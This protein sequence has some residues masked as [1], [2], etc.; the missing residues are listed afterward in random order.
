MF[1]FGFLGFRSEHVGIDTSS[2]YAAFYRIKNISDLDALRYEPGFLLVNKVFSYYGLGPRSVMVLFSLII[3]VSVFYFIRAFSPS[4]GISV[5]LYI[6]FYYYFF[7][8]NGVRQAVSISL[9]CLGYTFSYQKRL[10][11]SIL[12]YALA[13]LFHYTSALFFVSLLLNR[14]LLGAVVPY[15]WLASL[16]FLVFDE[17]FSNIFLSLNFLVPDVYSIY[18]RGM[19]FIGGI[20][21][22]DLLYQGFF[23]LIYFSYRRSSIKVNQV[24]MLYALL[25]IVLSNILTYSGFITRISYYWEIFLVVALPLAV[26]GAFHA[27]SRVVLYFSL[28]IISTVLYFR[29]VF[30]SSNGVMPYSTWLSPFS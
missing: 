21:V 2:Y 30:V 17:L 3:V 1:L 14:K 26:C 7:A 18:I 28:F 5:L 9:L 27:W 19:D 16:P 25:G 24:L 29:G 4:F 20:N 6:G 13:P 8:F 22:R 10:V 12:A 23:I 11:S 15:L